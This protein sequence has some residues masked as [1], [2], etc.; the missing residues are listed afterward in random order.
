MNKLIKVVL[1][2]SLL[3]AQPDIDWFTSYNGSGEESHGHF[4]IKCDDGGFLQIGETNFLPNS[5]ILVAVSY[6][7]LTL[8]TNR[9]V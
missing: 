6:T 7:H 1:L 9:E 2:L 8:P 3:N 5:K 4:I